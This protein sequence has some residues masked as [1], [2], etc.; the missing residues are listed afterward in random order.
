MILKRF[1]LRCVARCIFGQYDMGL[2]D[3]ATLW[4]RGSNDCAFF[5]YVMGQQRSFDF[6]TCDIVTR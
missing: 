2:N 4:I 6:G 3:K 5:H 1:C